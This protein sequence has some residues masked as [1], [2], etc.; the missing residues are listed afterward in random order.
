MPVFPAV[1]STT[2]PPDFNLRT[3]Y[4]RLAERPSYSLATFFCVNDDTEGGAILDTPT[5]ILELCFSEDRA[6]SLFRE[7]FQVDLR[8][9]LYTS[10]IKIDKVNTRGV[11]PTAPRNPLTL[12][13]RTAA[14]MGKDNQCL[15]MH[16]GGEHQARHS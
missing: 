9:G 16:D 5:R 15:T 3:G 4:L 10:G 2:V 12:R 1:P 11:L 7:C 14:M 13:R 8:L 6:A